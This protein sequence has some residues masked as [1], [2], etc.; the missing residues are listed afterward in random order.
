MISP[1][2]GAGFISPS[3]AQDIT[4]VEDAHGCCVDNVGDVIGV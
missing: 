2:A 1:G 4:E 3:L